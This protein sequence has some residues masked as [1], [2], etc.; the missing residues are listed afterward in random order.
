MQ[1]HENDAFLRAVRTVENTEGW[2]L[3]EEYGPY[4]MGPAARRYTGGHGRREAEVW[5]EYIKSILRQKN[6][7]P[8]PYNVAMAWN[9]GPHKVAKG[10]IPLVSYYY[11][12][13]VCNVF[14]RND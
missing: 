6:V 2:G 4:Q 3:A 1:R 12:T 10:P 11:A 13:M 5:L 7:H 8:G 14:G 9:C